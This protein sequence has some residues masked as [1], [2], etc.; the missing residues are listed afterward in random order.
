MYVDLLSIN[1]KILLR[2]AENLKTL[3]LRA[4]FRFFDFF[5]YEVVPVNE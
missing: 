1:R 4:V 5:S 2:Y 3:N